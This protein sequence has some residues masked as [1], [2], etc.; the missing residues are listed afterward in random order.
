MEKQDFSQLKAMYVNCTLKKSPEKSHTAGLMEVSKN[1]MRKEGVQV[2][3]LRLVDHDVA[4]GVYPN[5]TAHG[6]E[7][8][9]WPTL[10]E[11]IFAADILIVGT[12]IWL[13]KKS[14]EAQKLIERLYSMSGKQ[15]NK[16]QYLYYGKV[17]GCIITGNE[18]GVKHC[19]MG[20]LYALQ[21]IGYSIPPQADAGWI[22]EVGPGPSYLDKESGAQENDFTNRNTTF[23]TYNL[24]H[25]AKMLKEKNGYPAYG[26][27]R[28]EWDNGNRWNFE[29]PEYR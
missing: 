4:S 21:H 18:D 6:W 12:P 8:D 20:I 23:M 29:N 10:F 9:E 26:N 7:K 28:K 15:N 14:S 1:I 27:S 25:L 13:G 22:G 5:M 2:E 11:R 19:A 3:E 16:G 17:G 24:L